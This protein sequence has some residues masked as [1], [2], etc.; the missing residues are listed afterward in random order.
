MK[1]TRIILNSG[2]VLLSL[3]LSYF[4]IQYAGL[5]FLNHE[6]HIPSIH[7]QRIPGGIWSFQDARKYSTSRDRTGEISRLILSLDLE[8]KVKIPGN[9]K[10]DLALKSETAVNVSTVSG[11]PLIRGKNGLMPDLDDTIVIEGSS[12]KKEKLRA[13]YRT[14]A[15]GR[16][17]T[18]NEKGLNKK[19]N[20]IFLGCSFTFGM[21]VDDQDTFPYQVRAK[22]GLNV[23]NFGISGSSPS[24]TLKLLKEFKSEYFGDIS[25]EDTTVVYTV[26]PGHLNRI[27]GT[28]LHFRLMKDSF[29]KQPYIFEDG[30]QLVIRNSFSEDKTYG[31]HFLHFLSRIHLLKVFGIDFPVIG[32]KHIQLVTRIFQEI[33]KELRASYPQVKN[34][35]VAFYPSNDLSQGNYF[36]LRDE[37]VKN[38]IKVLDYSMLNSNSLL[39]PHNTLE[40]DIHPSPLAYDLYSSLLV[41]DLQ[42]SSVQ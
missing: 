15:L 20:L 40:Y 42:K 7:E 34:F 27:I 23:F 16:R 12:S 18:G 14:D 5:Y 26:I 41:Y 8:K 33:E 25:K 11:K 13:H 1:S 4:V 37:L 6:T 35:Y 3:F 9:K 17:F 2:L 24:V 29:Y 39:W 30:D 36:A 21:G 10:T 31:K 32:R 38:S 22:T 19:K 28:S